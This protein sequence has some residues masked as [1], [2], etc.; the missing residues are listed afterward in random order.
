MGRT[1]TC[2]NRHSPESTKENQHSKIKH[3]ILV[4]FLA[5]AALV[6][7]DSGQNSGDNAAPPGEHAFAGETITLV[8]G[9]DAS[10]GGTTVGRVLA[11]H[12]E[13]NLAGNPTVI[14]NNM[15]GASGLNAQLHVLL[16]ATDDG[17]T[18]YCGRR[19]SLGELLG[20][21]GFTL[22]RRTGL[23]GAGAETAKQASKDAWLAAA[24]PFFGYIAGLIVLTLLVG[25]K[26]AIPLFIAAYLIRWGKYSIG[27]AATYALG[28]WA[29]IVF[30]YDQ[31]MGLLFHPS[32][33]QLTVQ[34][35]LPSAFPEWLIF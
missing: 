6:S 29:L 7:C 30:F 34:P 12:L 15:P 21:P 33:L 24:L 31:V 10:A 9:L 8:I 1:S 32:Y 28:A 16:R 4:V 17:T 20:L 2:R 18:L 11:T 27:I 13:L 26:I 35:L 22:Y 25:Q 19:S 5:C 14:V 23:S 3:R